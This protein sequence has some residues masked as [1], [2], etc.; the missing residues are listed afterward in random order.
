[1]HFITPTPLATTNWIGPEL[2]IIMECKHLASE[3]ASTSFGHRFR[4]ANEIANSL[5]KSC[6]STRSSGFWDSNVPDFISPVLVNDLAIIRGIKS[7]NYP[8]NNNGSNKS[9]IDHFNNSQILYR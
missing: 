9:Q 2:S 5:A 6:T 8:K 7:G 4:E 1:M 3:F